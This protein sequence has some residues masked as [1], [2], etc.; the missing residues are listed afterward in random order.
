MGAGQEPPPREAVRETEHVHDPE[1]DALQDRIRSL[2]T[3][4]VLTALLALAGLGV[5]LWALLGE[6]DDEGG[7][8][9]A[10]PSR[11]SNLEDRVDELESRIENRATNGDIQDLEQ[12]IQEVE[13]QAQQAA[14]GGD[15]EQLQQSIETLDENVQQLDQRV[16][17]LEQQQ[18]QGGAATEP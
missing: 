11:V 8:R 14:E 9:G 5:A 7:S 12:R 2:T 13:Q 1:R 6:D 18:Q 4:L 15:T 3:A 10:S 17:E 16:E